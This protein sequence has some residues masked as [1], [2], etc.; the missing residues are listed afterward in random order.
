MGNTIAN[1]TKRRVDAGFPAGPRTANRRRCNEQRIC[2]MGRVELLNQCAD[3]RTGHDRSGCTVFRIVFINYQTGVVIEFGF[4]S[5]IKFTQLS[6]L[7]VKQ[8]FI[9]N[10][11]IIGLIVS[12]SKAV[13]NVLLGTFFRRILVRYRDVRCRIL[14]GY[15]F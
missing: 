15:C 12:N 9:R 2:G 14:F 10:I 4:T 11:F 3:C 7:F 5:M 13:K 8:L 6:N 1:L